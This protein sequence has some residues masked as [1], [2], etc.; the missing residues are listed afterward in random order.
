MHGKECRR[1]RALP[2]IALLAVTFLAAAGCTMKKEPP[3]QEKSPRALEQVSICQGGI[4]A[5]LPRVAL[6]EGFF[7]NEGI[8]ATIRTYGDGRSAMDAFLDGTCTVATVGEP[9]I[10][11]QS[12]AR[13]DFVILASVVTSDNATKI[14][15]RRDSGIGSPADLKGKRIG[16]RKGTI[17]HFFFDV[18][19]RKY[20]LK[21]KDT[22][23][24]FMELKEMPSALAS[25][26]IDAYS[27]SDLFYLEGA[28]LL[29]ERGVTF[30][31]PG[32]CFNA[33]HLV[34]RKEYLVSH[35]D[36]VRSLLAALLQAEAYAAAN[37]AETLNL[38]SKAHNIPVKDLETILR[39]E[40]HALTLSRPLLLSLED[41]ARW[42]AD[43]GGKEKRAIPNYLDYIDPAPLR[44]L[45]PD[46]VSLNH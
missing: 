40:R 26:T 8:A 15:A 35:P 14:L 3:R 2:A 20:G 33:A 19:L 16:I 11:K 21:P 42:M 39:D 31:E 27:S 37:P 17:S 34:V 38:V 10:V 44:R 32:L 13:D 9:P 18:F 12:F 5:V 36:Q 22:T 4:I 45:K 46:A 7:R 43:N 24:R 6:D 23:V 25:G 29:A 30:T 28:R 41:H 1:R